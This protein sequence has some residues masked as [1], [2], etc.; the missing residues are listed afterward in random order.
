MADFKKFNLDS[1]EEDIIKEIQSFKQVSDTPTES[2]LYLNYLTKIIELKQLR[3][4]LKE[5]GKIDNK[6]LK[7]NKGLLEENKK[8]LN[9]QNGRLLELLL[10]H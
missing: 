3:A 7:I 8:H 4:I 1:A 6:N 5:Q 2:T 10:P 9:I